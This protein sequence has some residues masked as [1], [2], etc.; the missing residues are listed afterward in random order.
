QLYIHDK[1]ASVTRPVK[2]LK[3]FQK[4]ILQPGESKQVNF[5][6]YADLLAFYNRHFEW[7]SEP[8]EFDLMIGTSSEDVKSFSFSLLAKQKKE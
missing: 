6:I 4:I 3:G 8:G 2:E 1:V 7:A 5:K